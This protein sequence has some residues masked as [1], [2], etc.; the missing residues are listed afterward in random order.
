M[1]NIK[2]QIRQAMRYIWRKDMMIEN[3]LKD[4][5]KLSDRLIVLERKLDIAIEGLKNI[6][7]Y[8]DYKDIA[9]KTLEEINNK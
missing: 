5:K 8:S 6:C 4:N 9:K 2:Y 3:L 1:K 7:E